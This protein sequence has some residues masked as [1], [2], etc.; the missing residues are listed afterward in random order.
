MNSHQLKNG[1]D[2]V[3]PVE[4]LVQIKP[5]VRI[6]SN[7]PDCSEELMPGRVIWQGIH[8]CVE[9]RCAACGI[10]L[11]E[12]LPIGQAFHTPYRVEL[13]SG[14]LL[15]S[16]DVARRWFGLPLLRSLLHPRMDEVGLKIE[17]LHDVSEVIILNCIDFLYG[18]ALLKLLNAEFHLREIRRTDPDKSGLIMI[19]PTYLRW[20]VPD[21]MAEIWTVDL[22]LAQSQEYFPKLHERIER[23]CMR[24]SKIYLSPAYSHPREFDIS[25]F[26]RVERHQFGSERFRITFI[27]REDRPW[28]SGDLLRRAARRIKPLRILLIWQNWRI[29]RFFASLRPYFPDATFT[30]AGLGVSTSFPKWIDDQRVDQF[31]EQREHNACRIYA[32]SRLVIGVHG[33]NLLLPSAHAGMLIDLMP[34]DRWGHIAQDVLYQFYHDNMQNNEDPRM[35]SWRFRYLPLDVSTKS[36]FVI[37]KCMLDGYKIARDFFQAPQKNRID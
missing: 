3:I 19:V 5:T 7:C 6:K 34:N 12:D 26:T 11:V 18:H 36:L 13:K 4:N 20:L 32:E 16:D 1:M 27:W 2:S 10:E 9:M 35:I 33:S 29:R 25:L 31:D 22:R 8:V 28:W 23:E 24:F 37:A 17:K 15:G 21:G 14:R 30:I